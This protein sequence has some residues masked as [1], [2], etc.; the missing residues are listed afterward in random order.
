M[1]GEYAGERRGGWEMDGK[2]QEM[3]CL[4]GFVHSSGFA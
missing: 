2:E 4:T 1:V 3:S